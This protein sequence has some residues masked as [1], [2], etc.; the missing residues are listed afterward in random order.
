MK[1]SNFCLSGK[2]YSAY[3]PF[4]ECFAES[5]SAA[6][7]CGMQWTP[8]LRV[9]SVDI[10]TGVQQDA[11]HH[12]RIVDTTLCS[13][14][15][16]WYWLLVKL[17]SPTQHKIGHFGDVSPSQSLGLVWK[18]KPNTTKAHTHQSKQMYYNTK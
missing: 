10:S 17:W 6:R 5:D 14:A 7:G 12:L 2:A 9:T 18:N 3:R 15:Q 11:E 8:V 4:T 1:I 13:T 16:P